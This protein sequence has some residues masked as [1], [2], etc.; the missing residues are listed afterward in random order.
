MVNKFI[1]IFTNFCFFPER[2]FP[3]NLLHSTNYFLYV[4][5][6]SLLPLI[7]H[8]MSVHT[9][10]TIR[11][12]WRAVWAINSKLIW[13]RKK[14]YYHAIYWKVYCPPRS[15]EFQDLPSTLP[16][17]QSRILETLSTAKVL[18]KYQWFLSVVKRCIAWNLC[19]SLFSY[20]KDCLLGWNFC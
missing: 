12:H 15:H 10:F 7:F 8:T 19:R 20:A 3:P 18:R 4:Y 6:I 1:N 11:G 13:D 16:W 2:E 5:C 9:Q 14:G 17:L